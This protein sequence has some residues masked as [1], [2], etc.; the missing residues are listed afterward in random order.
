[1]ILISDLIYCKIRLTW[2]VKSIT[3]QQGKSSQKEFDKG[4]FSEQEQ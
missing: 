2:E 1:M 4:I 3:P